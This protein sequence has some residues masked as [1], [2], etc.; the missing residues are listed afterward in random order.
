MKTKLITFGLE[1]GDFNQK[2]LSLKMEN[3][4]DYNLENALATMA[5]AFA[6]GIERKVAQEALRE[7]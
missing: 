7:I 5:V 6:L 4:G 3:S 2:I 1:K